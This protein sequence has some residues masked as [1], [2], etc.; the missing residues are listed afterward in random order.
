MNKVI[1]S[2]RPFQILGFLQ[3]FYPEMLLFVMLFLISF[4]SYSQKEDKLLRKGNKLYEQGKYKDAELNYRKALEINKESSK[5]IFNLGAAT[6][7]EKNYEESAK[8][9]SNLADSRVDKSLKAKS[10]HNLGNS[11]LEAKEYDKSINAYEQALLNNPTD[12]DTKYNLEYAKQMLKKQQE[13]QQKDKNNQNKDKKD[14][15]KQDQK[16]DQ[17]NKDQNQ[18]KSQP[19]DQNKKIS[20][21]D[22]ERMLEAL[23]NDE[24]KTI[25]KLKKEKASPQNVV[26]EKDW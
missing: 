2:V 16:K 26:V 22:A 12:K 11:F 10:L 9:F 4:S 5:G 6:Y 18:Q 20:K 17:Q 25:A 14:K 13:Q 8:L 15:D 7:K 19:Q 23:K 3:G 21:E 24:K 1:K